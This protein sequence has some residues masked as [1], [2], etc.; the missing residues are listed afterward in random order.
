VKR[1]LPARVSTRSAWSVWPGWQ[2]GGAV[3]L[4]RRQICLRICIPSKK[5]GFLPKGPS[6]SFKTSIFRPRGQHFAKGPNFFWVSPLPLKCE[7]I[8]IT[9][10]PVAQRVRT[11]ENR[12]S[13]SEPGR[14]GYMSFQRT[15]HGPIDANTHN[16]WRGHSLWHA[17]LSR[18]LGRCQKVFLAAPKFSR[19][20]AGNAE[21]EE[22][23]MDPCEFLGVSTTRQVIFNQYTNLEP[24]ACNAGL[25]TGVDV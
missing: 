18:F 25:A 6:F 11:L 12:A 9:R 1:F 20:G 21:E 5:H 4:G 17:P 3:V 15:C 24:R 13:S 16:G 14:L 2:V 8:S 19:R 7:L 23:L 22:P 10:A